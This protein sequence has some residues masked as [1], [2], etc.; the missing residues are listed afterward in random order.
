LDIHVFKN[1]GV[2]VLKSD[3][4]K[5]K[6]GCEDILPFTQHCHRELCGLKGIRIQRI[7]EL[8]VICHEQYLIDIL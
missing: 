6:F 1:L 7:R 3:A 5:T 8:G 2:A 4:F